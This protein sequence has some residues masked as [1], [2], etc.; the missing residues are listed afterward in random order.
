MRTFETLGSGRK[1]VT[2]N[3]N[4]KS[5][6]FYNDTNVYIIDR[7]NPNIDLEFF[8]R[9]FEPIDSNLL[10]AMSLEGWLKELFEGKS[11]IW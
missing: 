1:L 9:E 5:Y 8:N 2:T 7:S 6:P 10:F 4:I 3:S 11:N